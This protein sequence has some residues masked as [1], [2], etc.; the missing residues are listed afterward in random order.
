MIC[1]TYIINI[2]VYIGAHVNVIEYVVQISDLN[3]YVHY[4]VKMKGSMHFF[5][6]VI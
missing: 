1:F 5:L 4:S 2:D 6:R 3:I